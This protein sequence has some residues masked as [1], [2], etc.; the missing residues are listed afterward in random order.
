VIVK[1]DEIRAVVGV[2]DAGN[3]THYINMSLNDLKRKDIRID[4][5]LIYENKHSFKVDLSKR[6]A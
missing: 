5:T 3:R 6:K 4:D 2:H 1:V